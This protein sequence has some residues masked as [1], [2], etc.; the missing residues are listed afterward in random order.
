MRQCARIERA[1]FTVAAP[2]DDLEAVLHTMTSRRFRHIPV[3]ES[4]GLVGM[5][6][7]GDMVKAQLNEYRGAVETLE[8][9]LMDA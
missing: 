5:L 8:T 3:V 1:K 7:I 4:G 9:Q 2:S 6:T